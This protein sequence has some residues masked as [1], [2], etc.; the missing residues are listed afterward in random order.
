MRHPLGSI[1]QAM[2]TPPLI[3]VLAPDVLPC[4]Y[5]SFTETSTM[6]QVFV[7]IST[8]CLANIALQMGILGDSTVRF[9]FICKCDKDLTTQ[10]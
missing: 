4:P 5:M 2:G 7:P 10:P 9:T 3:P 8:H 6:A 1:L